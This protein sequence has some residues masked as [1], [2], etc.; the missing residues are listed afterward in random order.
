MDAETLAGAILSP[1]KRFRF[2]LRRR[3]SL[4]PGVVCWVM[5]NPSTAD[6]ET[7]DP[8]IR[9]C[10]DFTRRWGYG[11]LVVVNLYPL[12]SPKP[13]DAL[14]YYAEPPFGADYFENRSYV[15][16][17]AER[18][19]LVVAAWGSHGERGAGDYWRERLNELRDDVKCLGLTAWG[20]PRH[21]LYV[22]A[23][24]PLEDFR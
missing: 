7:N 24:T 11:E 1:C 21:P 6:A 19:D 9:R 10:I 22:K 17:A 20:Q 12:R 23:D 5:L 18:A 2:E 16:R 3:V 14:R 15:E 4:D 13:A 8:T